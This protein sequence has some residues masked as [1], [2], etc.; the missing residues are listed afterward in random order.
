MDTYSI[1]T[2]KIFWT[3]FFGSYGI[4]FFGRK[5]LIIIYESLV[6]KFRVF[7]T[8]RVVLMERGGGCGDDAVHRLNIRP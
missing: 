4:F 6:V 7:D 2:V 1:K 5:V 8:F 3:Y